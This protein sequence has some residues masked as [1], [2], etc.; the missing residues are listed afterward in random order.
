MKYWFCTLHK[1]LERE[2]ASKESFLI[3]LKKHTTYF[4]DL[5]KLGKCMFAGQL[6]DQ[7]TELGGGIYSFQC[8]TEEEAILLANGDPLVVEGLYTYQMKEWLLVAP[9]LRVDSHNPAYDT[10]CNERIEEEKKEAEKT[11]EKLW[12][13]PENRSGDTSFDGG[14]AES[15]KTQET[16]DDLWILPSFV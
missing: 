15:I 7:G 12:I 2:Q 8:E 14:N 13:L 4:K 3:A 1:T 11:E 5:E 6:L 16:E 10:G 9:D